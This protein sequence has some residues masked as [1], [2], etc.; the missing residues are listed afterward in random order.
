MADIPVEVDDVRHRPGSF[1]KHLL[2]MDRFAGHHIDPAVAQPF[3]YLAGHWHVTL[4]HEQI[5]VASRS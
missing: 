2:C 4:R 5:A 1:G 3:K